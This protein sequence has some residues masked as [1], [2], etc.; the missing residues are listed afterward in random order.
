MRGREPKYT[1]LVRFA[2]LRIESGCHRVE[3]IPERAQL[4]TRIG[5]EKCPNYPTDITIYRSST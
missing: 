4:G 3:H 5:I 2:L 1:R